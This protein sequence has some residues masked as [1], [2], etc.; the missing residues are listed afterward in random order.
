VKEEKASLQSFGNSAS[1]GRRKGFQPLCG[2]LNQIK[3]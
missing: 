1:G 2:D 3:Q